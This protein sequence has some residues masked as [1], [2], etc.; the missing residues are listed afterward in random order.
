MSAVAIRGISSLK[1]EDCES[2]FS[3]GLPFPFVDPHIASSLWKYVE[4][5]L[6]W[7]IPRFVVIFF[8]GIRVSFEIFHRLETLINQTLTCADRGHLPLKESSLE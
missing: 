2:L 4:N 8:F 3:L 1:T 6:F 5:I 7:N